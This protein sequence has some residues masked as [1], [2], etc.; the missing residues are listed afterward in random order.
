M[1]HKQ[2]VG[3]CEKTR[4][5]MRSALF[6]VNPGYHQQ[7]NPAKSKRRR[8]VYPTGKPMILHLLRCQGL[9]VGDYGCTLDA[10]N[11]QHPRLLQH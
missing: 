1:L 2:H 9:A 8:V 5:K 11:L 10:L 7:L 6:D 3:K 4:I